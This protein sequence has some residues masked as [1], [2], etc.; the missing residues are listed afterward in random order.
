M[1]PVVSFADTY[2]DIAYPGGAFQLALLFGWGS[3]VGGM[4]I[5]PQQL[6]EGYSH[7][8]LQ[9]WDSQFDR[10]VFFLDEWVEHPTYDDYW[11]QRGIQQRYADV[12]VPVLNVGG[13]YDIFSKTTI[14]TVDRVR[15]ESKNRLVRRNQY[16]VMGPWGHGVGARKVGQLDFGEAAALNIGELQFKWFEYWMR[17]QETGVEDWPA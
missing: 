12:T 5:T 3:A 14:E 4:N 17:G 13:W 6:I 16:V 7:L 10:D 8:P 11:R 2:H 1:V 9:D 15:R